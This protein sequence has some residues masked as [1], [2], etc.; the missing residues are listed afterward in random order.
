MLFTDSKRKQKHTCISSACSSPLM[1]DFAYSSP[2][3]RVGLDAFY[4]NPLILQKVA[5][6][7]KIM[8]KMSTPRHEGIYLLMLNYAL[9]SSYPQ[10]L[11]ISSCVFNFGQIFFLSKSH[12]WKSNLGWFCAWRCLSLSFRKLATSIHMRPINTWNQ[13]P[14][15]VSCMTLPS[16]I[17]THCKFLN[18]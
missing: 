4:R 11:G 1:I 7:L 16:C 15:S 12:F 10:L 13:V 6:I 18:N 2:F 14:H 17:H 9:H 5:G 3:S 8:C